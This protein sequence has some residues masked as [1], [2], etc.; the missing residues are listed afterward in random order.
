MTHKGWTISFLERAKWKGMCN[1]A[2]QFSSWQS[3][4]SF[5]HTAQVPAS[6]SAQNCDMEGGGEGGHCPQEA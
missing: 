4:A 5:S 3:S 1:M 2:E 6:G